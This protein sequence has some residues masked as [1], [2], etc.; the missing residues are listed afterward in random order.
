MPHC[1]A[2]SSM[3]AQQRHSPGTQRSPGWHQTWLPASTASA[4]VGSAPGFSEA[5]A[6]D[7]ALSVQS[8]VYQNFIHKIL[9]TNDMKFQDI[10]QKK[11]KKKIPACYPTFDLIISTFLNVSIY[12]C[13]HAHTCMCMK[14]NNVHDMYLI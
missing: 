13:I 2:C 5:P 4:G 3:I 7:G 10:W 9:F 12:M 1:P 8:T 6:G 14:F 11:K